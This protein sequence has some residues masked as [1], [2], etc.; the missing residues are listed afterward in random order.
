MIVK[1]TPELAESFFEHLQIL[2]I[3]DF[4]I[5]VEKHELIEIDTNIF[6]EVNITDN[7][8]EGKIG[9]AHV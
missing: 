8:L 4:E 1:T 6:F 5:F 3:S 7:L 2:K 9:R